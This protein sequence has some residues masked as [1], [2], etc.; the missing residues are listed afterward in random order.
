MLNVEHVKYCLLFLVAA[1]YRLGEMPKKKKQEKKEKNAHAVALGQ[2]SA[3][4][5][6]QKISPENR[7][8]I[9]RNAAQARWAKEKKKIT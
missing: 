6:L 9:A 3:K 4:A 7:R 8:E 5:R 1:R 2:M